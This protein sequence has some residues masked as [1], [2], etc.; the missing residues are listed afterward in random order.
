MTDKCTSD[1]FIAW[2]CA[3]VLLGISTKSINARDVANDA[4]DDW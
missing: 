3:L 2:S 4:T 1:N